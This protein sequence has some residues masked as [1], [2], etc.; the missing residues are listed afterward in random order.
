M[1]LSEALQELSNF[2]R[3]KEAQDLLN[4]IDGEQENIYKS[5][6]IL[7]YACILLICFGVSLS[8]CSV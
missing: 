1:K 8:L 5:V 4:I 2:L 6:K 3:T 7:Y